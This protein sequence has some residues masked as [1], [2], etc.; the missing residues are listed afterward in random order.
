MKEGTI[1]KSLDELKGLFVGEHEGD[2]AVCSV[3]LN[4]GAK[5]WKDISPLRDNESGEI[6]GWFV[7]HEIDDT[8]EEYK[9]DEELMQSN[10]GK[11][12]NNN[13]LVFEWF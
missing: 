11:A 6:S 7:R 2:C 5:S 12:L 1:I 10:I 13:A 9:T 4:G 8:E 3:L